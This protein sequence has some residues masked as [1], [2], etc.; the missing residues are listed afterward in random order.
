MASKLQLAEGCCRVDATLAPNKWLQMS[1][2]ARAHKHDKQIDPHHLRGRLATSAS[3]RAPPNG[4]DRMVATNK[5]TGRVVG[6]I[7]LHRLA[8]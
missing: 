7:E 2:P 6:A 8:S 4:R 3:G 5:Q 1:A